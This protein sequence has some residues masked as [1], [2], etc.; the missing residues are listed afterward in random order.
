VARQPIPS[1]FRP[2][3][4]GRFGK[5]VSRPRLE[6]HPEAHPKTQ[7]AWTTLFMAKDNERTNGCDMQERLQ[8][9]WREQTFVLQLNCVPSPVRPLAF[10]ATLVIGQR[11]ILLNGKPER[12]TRRYHIHGRETEN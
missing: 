2:P 9:S 8:Q 11:Q 3:N 10:P 5:M 12:K 7:K 1:V 6:R 4:F